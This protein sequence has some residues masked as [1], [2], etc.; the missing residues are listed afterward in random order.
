MKPSKG[1]WLGRTQIIIG[2]IPSKSNQ[3]KT[4][5]QGGFYKSTV[6]KDYERSFWAQCDV[7]RNKGINDKFSI[8]VDVYL[9]N[10]RQ[11]LDGCFKILLDSLQSCGAIMNDKL[12]YRI[13][14]TKHIDSLNPRIEFNLTLH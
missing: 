12:C 3:Y 1:E 11:D 14:A 8:E 6:V 4:T 13:V 7:Y 9:K 10:P 5:K 2:A